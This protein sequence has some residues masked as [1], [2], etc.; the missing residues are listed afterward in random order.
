MTP[1]NHIHLGA[2]DVAKTRAFYERW[3]GFAHETDHGEG[4]FLRG[5]GRHLLAIDPVSEPS[6]WPSWF[7]IGF[8][9]DAETEVRD[10][11]ASMTEAAVEMATEL[12]DFPGEA[13]AFYCR[14]PDGVPI[15][16]S[17][18]APAVATPAPDSNSAA[19]SNPDSAP[20][21]PAG[22][23]LW[24]DL[25]VA[26]PEALIPFYKSVV[27]WD[28]DEHPM[29]DYVDYNLRPAGTEGAAAGLC[30]ARGSNAKQPPHWM[31][32]VSVGDVA[33]SAQAAVEHG[34]EVVDGPRSMGGMGYC[35]V[36]DPAGAVL[37]LL[38]PGVDG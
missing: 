26:D 4:V 8:C 19:D 25:T 34:G 21:T 1:M 18:H 29:G 23:V 3:F 36:R 30:H 35:C 9:L 27:G 33:A 28:L 13:V 15:E 24:R 17:W 2:R 37:G 14:D 20:S 22:T 31:V 6:T 7:H 11:H 38:G 12:R 10:L 32:Y 16:V 5:P